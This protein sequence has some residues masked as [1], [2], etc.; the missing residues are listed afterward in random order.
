MNKDYFKKAQKWL[1]EEKYNNQVSSNF[2][3]DLARLKQGEPLDYLIGFCCFL[4]C[5]I[6]LS[7]RPLIPRAETEYWVEKA[8]D[9]IKKETE[10]VL[11]QKEIVCLDMFAGSGCIG[12][13]LLKNF[14]GLKADFAEKNGDFLK[15]I[16]VNLKINGINAKRYRVIRSNV[17][18][19]L[20]KK[21]KYDYIFANPPYVSVRRKSKVERS[22]LKWE[23][24]QAIFGGK[25]GLFY[26][27]KFLKEA[28]NFLQPTGK[29][30]LEFDSFQKKA[31]EKLIKDC[32][33]KTCR[34]FKDQYGRWRYLTCGL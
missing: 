8:F 15:Q 1:L 25:D 22:V 12:V 5:K 2:K 19:R 17:F 21:R 7:F 29:I 9:E 11:P 34:V 26:I 30:Y 6:N 33:Y 28:K 13:S 16:K 20:D 31:I 10:E 4:D 3:K 14:P 23:P 27:K 18:S 24:A 32:G